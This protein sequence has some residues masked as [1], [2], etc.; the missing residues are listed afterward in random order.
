MEALNLLGSTLYLPE[1]YP[2]VCTLQSGVVE[3]SCIKV[4]HLPD[5]LV[6][7]WDGGEGLWWEGGCGVGRMRWEG[8]C[9]GMVE[10][11]CGGR[12]V[13]GREGVVGGRVWGRED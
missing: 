8:G 11:V 4:C 7:W 1:L 3:T 5:G 10:R 13:W 9:G 12:G 2:T 6:V